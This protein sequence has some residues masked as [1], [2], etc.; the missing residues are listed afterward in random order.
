MIEREYFHYQ[1]LEEFHAGMWRIVRG[2]ERVNNSLKA[3]A[4]MREPERFKFFMR[5]ATNEWPNSC[6]HNLTM[7][8]S[9]RLAWLGH[10][11]CCL[12]VDSP[13][14]NTRVGWHM[15]DSVEQDRANEAAQEVLDEWL[16]A[17]DVSMQLEFVC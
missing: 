14:E 15:L 4:L 1:D 13:E 5:K 9:N 10:A 6:R 2:G 16:S 3:A 12:G 8:N 7:E 11:G 17:N